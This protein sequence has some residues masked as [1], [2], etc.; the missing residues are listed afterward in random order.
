VEAQRTPGWKISFDETLGATRLPP[1]I[2]TTLFGVAQEA[3]TN[4][5]KHA[6]TTGAHLALER[7]E[8]TIRLAVQDWG[9]GFEPR[10]GLQE[11]SPGEH[12]GLREMR[13]RVEL[14]GGHFAIAS[15]PGAGTL[16][17]AEVPPPS[18]KEGD[19]FHEH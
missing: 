17:V 16:V 9:R 12:V 6:G 8:R 19:N 4:A 14:V 7:H 3:L 18:S 1:R 11:A 2:E 5:R 15:Q 10:A 13:E